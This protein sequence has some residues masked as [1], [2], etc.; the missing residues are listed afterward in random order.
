[1]PPADLSSLPTEAT[2]YLLRQA[3]AD[4]V[5]GVLIGSA[6][7]DTI[8]LYTEF[9]S[10][11]D[12]ATAY[13]TRRFTLCGPKNEGPTLF[14][15]DM[16]RAPKEPGHWTDD[17]D[18]ALLLLLSFLL[19]ASTDLPPDKQPLP[20]Q[21]D[22]AKRLRVWVRQGLPPLDTLPLGLGRTV[23]SIV[24]SAGFDTSPEAVAREYWERTGRVVA[25]NGSLMRTHPLGV[26]CLFREEREAF[27]LAAEISR[28]THVDPRCVVACV[29]GTGLVRGLVNGEVRDWHGVEGVV[30]RGVEWYVKEGKQGGD[31]DWKEDDWEHLQSYV[32][33]KVGLDELKLDEHGAI[34][35]VYKTLGSGV[36]LLRMAMERLGNGNEGFP[37]KGKVFEELITDLVMHGGDADTNACFAGALLGA[38]LGYSALPGHWKHGLKHGDW[39]SGK[40]EALCRALGLLDGSYAGVHDPD[41]EIYGG[42]YPISDDEMEQRWMLLQADVAAKMDKSAKAE[43]LKAPTSNPWLRWPLPWPPKTRKRG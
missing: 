26:I 41:T 2:S 35:Y 1:M 37:Q 21:A 17:T 34:G 22:L 28:V 12:A 43:A 14:K 38:Y 19:T 31:Q 10:A 5:A 20:T 15:L 7:G 3:L 36:V 18:H 24:A 39:L 29:I 33:R 32:G 30:E 40:V 6:L 4:R 13:P 25:P 23:G 16:H 8:G 42:K 27:A 11:A 9:L